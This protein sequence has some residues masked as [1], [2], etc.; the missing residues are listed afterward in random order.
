MANAGHCRPVLL[1]ANEP[2]RWAVKGLGPALGFEPGLEFERTELTLNPGDALILYSDA[3]TE[4]FNPQD[5]CYGNHRLLA[6]ARGAAGQSAPAITARLLQNVRVFAGSASQS[7]DLAILTLKV[8]DGARMPLELYATPEAVMRS[9]EALQEFARAHRVPEKSIF[10]LAL[11]LE[12]CGSNVVNHALK[13]DARRTF[14]VVLE[15]T[16][17]ALVVELCDDGLE[18]DPT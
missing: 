2:P 10:G 13:R 16:R 3:V 4:A 1:P 8:N 17:D 7:D 15:R 6:D 12:E 5:E 9:V 14:Q 18:F 11:A